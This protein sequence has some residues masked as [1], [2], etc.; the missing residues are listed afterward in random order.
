MSNKKFRK[1]LEPAYIGK[2]RTRNRFIKNGT[3]LFY[4]TK[5][6]RGHMKDTNIAGYEALSK[7]GVGLL[8]A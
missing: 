4:D 8:V 3:G 2:V 5:A 6:D 1:L 7:G